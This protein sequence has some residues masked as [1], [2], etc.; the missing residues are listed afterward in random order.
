MSGIARI[1]L[2]RGIA[3]LRQRREGLGGAR[4]AARAR[5]DG[6]TSATT[7]RNVG[8]ADTVVVSTAIR[9][10]QPRA[11]RGA[12]GAACGS[13]PRAAALASR[14]GRA[15]RRRGR[16][17]ARQDDDDVDAHG[18]AAALRRRPV[19]R[20]RR[21][22]QRVRRQRPRRHRRRLRRR[23]RRERRLVPALLARRSPI[24]TN[25]E[26]DHLDHYGTAEAVEQ[27]FDAFVERVQPGRVP[28]R[29]RRRP[30]RARGWPRRRR[31]RGVDV[32]TYG[33]STPTPTC[34]MVDLATAAGA[35]RR[36]SR[37]RRGR[38]LGRVAAAAARPAQRAQRRGGAARP[39]LGLGLPGRA[40]A[41]RGSPASPAPGGGSSSRAPSAG[42][43]VFDDYAH[44]PTELR[45]DARRP[46]A[47]SPS[48]GRVVVVLPAA[49]AT[50]GPGLR[51]RSSAPRSGWPT[52]SSSWT[53]TP[54]ARTR[55]PGVTGALVAAAVPLPPAQVVSRAVVVGGRRPAG[56]AGRA[57]A[58]WC[59]PSAPAT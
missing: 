20:D 53:C 27:A 55:C 23:G 5:R 32:R 40:A 56:R 21:Q 4:R 37:G 31:G 52:R 58:T 14:D 25:V 57:R 24:V 22:P 54:R 1:M 41:R 47:R 9:D 30:G 43:R 38:R 34:G 2:A 19:V 15:A 11:G 46:P 36:S 17:H 16:R 26:P 35:A 50:A 8:E 39:A 29:L 13:L 3:G 18:R 28:G 7:P 49:P 42:V 45:A 44:H 10:D 59:S 51:R 48:G 33:E 12:R 6:R